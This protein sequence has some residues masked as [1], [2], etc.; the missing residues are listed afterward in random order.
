MVDE[1]PASSA[2]ADESASRVGLLP[3]AGLARRLGI[4]SPKELIEVDDRPVIDHSVEHLVAVGVERVVVV[5]R[6]GKEAIGRHLD[7]SH[8]QIRFD[9]VEQAGPIGNL[10]DAVVAAADAIRGCEVYFLMPDTVIEPNPFSTERSGEVTLLCF[11]AEGETW[12]NYGVVADDGRGIVEKPTADVGSVCWGAL[13]WGPEFT[14]RLGDH[15]DLT[16][17]MN[18]ADWQHRI[19]IDTYVD[20]GVPGQG[21][22][23]WVRG[24]DRWRSDRADESHPGAAGS[25]ERRPPIR[26]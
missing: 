6:P 7:R 11:R 16:G 12:R 23:E 13:R 9:Y 3:A 26:R 10:H 5:V 18:A 21:S 19:T 22:A 8:P 2:P 14:E 20:I 15:H 4:D 1:R 25:S 24:H 17:A